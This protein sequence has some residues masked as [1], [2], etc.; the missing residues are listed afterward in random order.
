MEFPDWV[1]V[2]LKTLWYQGKFVKKIHDNIIKDNVIKF[3]PKRW[4]DKDFDPFF[5]QKP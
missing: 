2:K 5:G 1:Q 3:E 4:N